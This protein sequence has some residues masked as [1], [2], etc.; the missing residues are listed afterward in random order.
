MLSS[1]ALYKDAVD[2][3]TLI[4]NQVIVTVPVTLA[5][6]QIWVPIIQK[7][8][9]GQKTPSPEPSFSQGCISSISVT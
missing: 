3:V 4:W 2:L 5:S 1:K 9:L 7:S 8:K 6:G